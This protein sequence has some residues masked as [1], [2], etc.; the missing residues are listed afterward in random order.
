M[1]QTLAAAALVAVAVF[2]QTPPGQ[3]TFKAPDAWK[4]RPAVSAMLWSLKFQP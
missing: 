2:A 1:Q 3:L 4:P